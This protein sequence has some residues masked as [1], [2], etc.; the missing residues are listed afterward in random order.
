MPF[1]DKGRKMNNGMIPNYISGK[2]FRRFTV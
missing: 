1:V 2:L